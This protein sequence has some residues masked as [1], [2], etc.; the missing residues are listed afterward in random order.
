MMMY[1]WSP[2]WKSNS[3]GND[4]YNLYVRLLV[5]RRP[6]LDHH[7]GGPGRGGVTTTENYCVETRRLT[8]SASSSPTRRALS[9]KDAT[10]R[11]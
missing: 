8:A 2:N 1:A 11:N 3:V 5:R 9:S 4:H 7:T 10:S 6:D